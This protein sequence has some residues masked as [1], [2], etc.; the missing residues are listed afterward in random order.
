MIER[1]HADF[2]PWPA[3]TDPI[4]TALLPVIEHIFAVTADGSPQR[5]SSPVSAASCKRAA[6]AIDVPEV[7]RRVCG[8]RGAEKSQNATLSS[9]TFLSHQAE[10]SSA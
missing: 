8:V 10:T 2:E 3:A 4:N 1:D 6:A 5:A 7:S 9:G